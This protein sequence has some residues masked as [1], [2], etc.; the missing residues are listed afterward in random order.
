MD[1]NCVY[2]KK[3]HGVMTIVDGNMVHLS[4]LKDYIT[5]NES[6]SEVEEILEE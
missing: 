3:S 1:F 5:E 2:C 4:C 6:D